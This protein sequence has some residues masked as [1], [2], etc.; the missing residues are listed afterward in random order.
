MW[1]DVEFR[2][3][4]RIRTILKFDKFRSQFKNISQSNKDKF[5]DFL[6]NRE[7]PMPDNNW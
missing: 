3:N 1:E 4:K 7:H 6:K 5:L 2:K